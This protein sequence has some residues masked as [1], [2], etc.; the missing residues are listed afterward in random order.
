[1]RDMERRDR[2]GRRD[3]NNDQWK[4]CREGMKDIEGGGDVEGRKKAAA[5]PQ[6][7]LPAHSLLL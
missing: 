1:M 6:D 5:E 2:I 4:L 3:T 7:H